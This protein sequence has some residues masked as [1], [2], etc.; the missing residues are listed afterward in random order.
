MVI[1]IPVVAF[2]IDFFGSSC[3]SQVGLLLQKLAHRDQEKLKIRQTIEKDKSQ[4]NAYC[5]FRFLFGM[6]LMLIGTIVHLS[7]LPFLD[8]TLVA[9]GAC[10]GIII[11]VILS[12][13]VLGEKFV[14]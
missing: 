11:A 8:M 4:A 3:V 2:F 14:W 12:V 10:L 6:S 7:V 1:S 13:L 9:G 5:S